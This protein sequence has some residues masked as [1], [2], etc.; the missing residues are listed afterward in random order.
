MGFLSKLDALAGSFSQG[1]QGG[2]QA[3][4]QMG[5]L[6]Q[7]GQRYAQQQERLQRGEDEE[8]KNDIRKQASR[9]DQGALTAA[10]RY[11]PE[12][13]A[14][15][16]ALLKGRLEG[17][18]AEVAGTTGTAQQ[19]GTG[20]QL[21]TEAGR[22][23]AQSDISAMRPALG[24]KAEQ[25][26]AQP[27]VRALTPTGAP[28]QRMQPGQKTV[29]GQIAGPTGP[30]A[31]PGTETRTTVSPMTSPEREVA[32]ARATQKGLGERLEKIQQIET[33]FSSINFRA[34]G[35]V[36]AAQIEGYVDSL[37]KAGV[38]EASAAVTASRLQRQSREIRAD[39]LM[40]MARVTDDP[41]T[42]E[43]LL[44]QNADVDPMARLMVEGRLNDVRRTR[45]I[46]EE[47]RS[48][49][50][51]ERAQRLEDR[52]YSRAFEALQM[53]ITAGELGDVDAATKYLTLSAD[54]FEKVNPDYAAIVL[55]NMP[56]WVHRKSARKWED[57]RETLFEMQMD[58]LKKMA[59]AEF[60]SSWY[61]IGD[62]K[63]LSL[64]E[65]NRLLERESQRYLQ[66]PEIQTSQQR[67][68]ARVD[69]Y[70]AAF[71][72]ESRDG[73]ERFV[74]GI[75]S[76]LVN[77]PADEK[78]MAIAALRRHGWVMQGSNIAPPGFYEQ[79]AQ[80]SG[81]T[82]WLNRNMRGPG[83]TRKM[84]GEPLYPGGPLLGMPSNSGTTSHEM[85]ELMRKL[86]IG[87]DWGAHNRARRALME[88]RS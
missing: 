66:Q 8:R 62:G 52:G 69:E 32:R 17:P 11:G 75:N 79:A 54:M 65:Y 41:E 35:V 3:G 42:L 33:Q 47:E 51:E 56:Q 26:A 1:L 37:I 50:K 28:G 60:A 38:P 22:A 53:G 27:G 88:G 71:N 7:Q 40:D 77:M 72:A 29:P 10:Q 2:L 4:A 55:Q 57:R 59:L 82:G 19:V 73:Q 20:A 6:R 39:Q 64:N 78:A 25:L 87:K 45:G 81:V 70:I 43:R 48:Y 34:P 76:D 67:T 84:P 13:V 49:R 24:Q 15:V 86:R 80:G 58:P 14:E 74:E 12:F 30:V 83:P 5:Q 61:S 18:T 63:K 46:Q 21:T 36:V 9:G 44:L 85:D 68:Q 23:Q 16:Q 31:V